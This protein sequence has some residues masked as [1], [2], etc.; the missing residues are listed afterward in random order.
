MINDPHI[1]IH[2]W[3]MMLSRHSFMVV[4]SVQVG[5]YVG[6]GAYFGRT[7]LGL[8]GGVC[9]THPHGQH[10]DAFTSLVLGG[11]GFARGGAG[12]GAGGGDLSEK[13]AA[14]DARLH[15]AEKRARS[16]EKE[17]KREKKSGKRAGKN[18]SAPKSLSKTDKE[19]PVGA[20]T[21][22]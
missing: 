10:W 3:D 1:H 13:L 6:G 9:S 2:T 11:V 18:P 21:C 5:C 14:A 15:S 12:G 19:P 17:L 4:G 7:R 20:A 16:V 8:S 22:H